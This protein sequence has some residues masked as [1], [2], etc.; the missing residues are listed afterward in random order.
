MDKIYNVGM[1]GFG[2][3]ASHHL[4]QSHKIERINVKG[5]YDINPERKEYA[6]TQGLYVYET[7]QELISDPEI[8]IVLVAV[9]N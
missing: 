4:K 8:D 7:R 3:M 2:G 5:I 9:P 6:K 1:I